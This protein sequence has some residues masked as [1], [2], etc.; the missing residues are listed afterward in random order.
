MCIHLSQI[1]DLKAQCLV[2]TALQHTWDGGRGF[3]IFLY[4]NRHNQN[5][6]IYI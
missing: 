5:I 4:I 2:P 6:Y 1:S 3:S